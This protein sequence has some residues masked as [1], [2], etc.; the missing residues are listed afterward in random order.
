[1]QAIWLAI[2]MPILSCS[3]TLNHTEA[4]RVVVFALVQKIFNL[5]E[6]S[7][8]AK[9][10]SHSYMNNRS[11]GGTWW[12]SFGDTNTPK[13]AFLS[14]LIYLISQWCVCVVFFLWLAAGGCYTVVFVERSSIWSHIQRFLLKHCCF[15]HWKLNAITTTVL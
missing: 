7:C 1:M 6:K 5:Y 14:S 4:F 10:I 9:N 2:Q 11:N 15:I 3:L 12:Q 13:Y 8:L